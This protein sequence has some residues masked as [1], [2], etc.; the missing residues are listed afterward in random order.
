MRIKE[1]L[2]SVVMPVYNSV[3]TIRRSIDSILNQTFSDF[4]FIIVNENKTNDGTTEIL[5]S[6]CKQDKRIILINKSSDE[7]LGI[8]I[9]L[10]LGLNLAKGK[11]IARMDA[12][13]YS[14]PDRFQKQYDFMEKNP[15]IVVCGSNR[16]VY[17]GMTYVESHVYTSP[18]EIRVFAL[19][20]NPVAHPTVMIR[21]EVLDSYGLRY[22]EDHVNVLPE[23][24]ELWL[25]MMSLGLKFSNINEVLL[26][27]S[28]DDTEFHL[29]FNNGS[30][31][32]RLIY[33]IVRNYIYNT[34][35]LDISEQWEEI[36]I[37]RI[38]PE[39]F[40]ESDTRRIIDVY[41]Y[42]CEIEKKNDEQNE[43]D[44]NVLTEI[45]IKIWNSSAEVYYV[46]CGL[47]TDAGDK[48][49]DIILLEEKN[50]DRSFAGALSKKINSPI[51]DI[52]VKLS[53][54]VDKLKKRANNIKRVIVFGKGKVVK[55]NLPIL[56]RT[57]DVIAFCDN[58]AVE[59]EFL[60]GKQ[61]IKPSQIIK[62]EFDHILIGS[63]IYYDVLEKQLIEECGIEK[64]KIASIE[65]L[66]FKE[67]EK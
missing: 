26:D 36:P 64:E 12:D 29:S 25:R 54:N 16:R 22:C 24:Y 50:N 11:Y 63:N 39:E 7:G 53:N 4:E 51:A 38:E 41:R 31:K 14:Y 27:Y 62:F 55:R 2:V 57:V 10:N 33:D 8:A 23:D 1:P 35:K 52:E 45:L 13:D 48:T 18:E 6:Y 9:S 42:L 49:L 46:G 43:F 5:E 59:S 56:N 61:V 67:I 30:E 37:M 60:D 47:N 28:S 17:T 32:K 3:K 19:F 34:I 21:R 44:K 15:D 65:M 20:G 58:K 66:K 40:V